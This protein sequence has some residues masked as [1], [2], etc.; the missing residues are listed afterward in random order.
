[1]ASLQT[2]SFPHDIDAIGGSVNL[3]QYAIDG[4]NAFIASSNLAGAVTSIGVREVTHTGRTGHKQT[5]YGDL[6]YNTI[7]V[8]AERTNISN[9]TTHQVIDIFVWNAY[10]VP[11]DL[12]G[13]SVSGDDSGLTLN[14]TASGTFGGL[15]YETYTLTAG[16]D[17]APV[18]DV[19]YT[20]DFDTDDVPVNFTGRRVVPFILR[21]NWQAPIN[22]QVSFKTDVLQPLSG[23]E[24]RRGLRKIPRRRIEMSYYTMSAAERSYLENLLYG[25]HKRPFL[26]PIWSDK[27]KLT[28]AITAGEITFFLDTTCKDFDIGGFI[29]LGDDALEIESITDTSVTVSSPA[30]NSYARGA[31]VAPAKPCV[32]ESSLRLD[33]ITNHVDHINVAWLVDTATDSVNRRKAYTIPTYRGLEVYD[34]SNDY[35]QAISLDQDLREH[36]FDAEVGLRGRSEIEEFPRRRYSFRNLM[37]RSELGEFLEWFH[38]REGQL[39]PFW[40]NER[41]PA[42]TLVADVAFNAV[43]MIVED[44][45]YTTLIN[46]ANPRQDIAIKI[47]GTWYY[48]RITGAVDNGDGTETL[49]IDSQLG[50]DILAATNPLISYLKCVRLAQ[51][52]VDL[53]YVTTDAVQGATSFIDLLTN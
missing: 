48:R 37:T 28:S 17:G 45:G 47:A 38:L 34:R 52:S 16:L 6:Y 13:I 12:N 10:F 46:T 7:W 36:I 53:S 9:M 27:T 8:I 21:H 26:V 41:T 25:W 32:M 30:L 4:T 39:T 22:E 18:F 15:E 20:W 49:T 43:T 14:G 11:N 2:S 50:V 44:V 19:T 40:F 31:T 3:E 24:Q 1:M 35:S 29:Y 42:F 51:D 5:S 33:R 23:K